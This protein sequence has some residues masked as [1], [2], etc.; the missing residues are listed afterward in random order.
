MGKENVLHTRRVK[1]VR[2]NLHKI[3]G[4]KAKLI[5]HILLRNCLLK[6]VTVETIE[7]II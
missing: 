7:G 4:Q 2:N 3:K 1:E 6:H 5:G